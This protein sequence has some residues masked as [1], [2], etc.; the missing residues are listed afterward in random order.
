MAVYF[1]TG[2]LGNGK[3]ILSV[4]RIRDALERNVPIATNLDIN[5]RSLVG[6]KAKTP[7]LIRVPDKPVLADLHAIG[8]G[9]KTYDE[10]KNGLL[11]LDEC[12]TWFNSRNWADK[13]R[14]DVINWLLHARKLG[15]DVIFIV[16]DISMIDKQARVALG[17]HVV[18]CRRLDRMKIPV[19]TFLIE[20][21]SL[22]LIKLRLPKIHVGIVKYGEGLQAMTVDKWWLFTTELYWAYDTK[23][24]FSDHYEHGAYSVLPPYYTHYRYR[25]P[26]TLRNLM[27][28]T[29]IYARK[30]SRPV[31]FGF[32]AAVAYACTLI[33]G[34]GSTTAPQV[35]E[36]VVAASTTKSEV[37]LSDLLN[38]FTVSSYMNPPG[39]PVVFEL[40]NN[41]RVLSSHELLAMGFDVKALSRCN[42][43]VAN[44]TQ[45]ETIYC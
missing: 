18:T 30:Y 21:A 35:V 24:A 16:Q 19:V 37:V 11:V 12:G 2:K 5:L 22:G 43:T 33:V 6:A 29:K 36:S 4:S 45:F 13:S 25:V 3:S 8:K 41:G 31:A 9:N 10:R 1:V 39:A 20:T 28:I 17:E 38:G 23:Q 32:G 42:V 34:V 40:S 27:R 14:V 15:W 44:G 7:R 26:M